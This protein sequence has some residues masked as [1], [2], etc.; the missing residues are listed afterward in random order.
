[1]KIIGITGGSG[2]GKTTVLHVLE[3]FDVRVIDCDKVYH[4]LLASNGQLLAE[5]SD[6]FGQAVFD[7]T[8]ALD[9]KALGSAVFNDVGA[10]MDLNAITHK[11]V[12]AEVDRQIEEARRDGRRAVAVDA[13]ALIE[14]GL[15]EKCDV[16]VAITAPAQMRVRRLM[17]RDGISEEYAN[18]RIAAQK[19]DDFFETHC[20]HVFHNDGDEPAACRARARTLFEEIL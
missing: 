5:L 19:P 18:L 1:M 12:G 3:E 17:V 15:G 4:E 16:T 10:L 13:I 7:G 8:G 6:R 20:D 2:A 11:Y 14:S 9:R